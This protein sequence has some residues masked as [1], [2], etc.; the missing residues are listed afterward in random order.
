MQTNFFNA[1][2]LRGDVRGFDDY[3]DGSQFCSN[4]FLTAL[5]DYAFDHT[6]RTYSVPQI[7][8][9]GN[10]VGTKTVT[11]HGA[12]VAPFLFHVQIRRHYASLD[13]VLGER[14]VNNYEQEVLK[15]QGRAQL[16]ESVQRQ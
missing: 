14:G 8:A 2:L 3:I 7:A 11:T 12:M 1:V 5:L 16:Q 4:G 13:P 10:S 9:D 15:L 6:K